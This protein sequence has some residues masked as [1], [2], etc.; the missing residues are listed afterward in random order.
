MNW[1]LPSYDKAIRI[2]ADFVLH[3]KGDTFG[4][5]KL[6]TNIARNT[7]KT[8]S[9]IKKE[10]KEVLQEGIDISLT[11]LKSLLANSTDKYNDLVLLEG[12][13]REVNQQLLQ[14]VITYENAQLEFNKIRKSLIDFI[15]T[16][17]ENHLKGKEAPD[18]KP[19]VYNGE[20]MYRIPKT[21]QIEK[22]VKC[23]VRVAFNRQVLM[24]GLDQEK[25][26]VLKDIRISDV[27]GVELL[28]PATTPAFSIRTFSEPVQFVE[29]D[30][31]TEWLFYVKPLCEGEHS[32]VLKISVIE[33]KE[34]I[35]RK[36][37]VVLE[38][39]VVIIAGPAPKPEEGEKFKPAGYALN[40]AAAAAA[41]SR[42]TTGGS[43]GHHRVMPFPIVPPSAPVVEVTQPQPSAPRP[44]TARRMR[45]LAVALPVLLIFVVASWALWSIF[46][47][48]L[49]NTTEGNRPSEIWN[50]VS[51]E[52][53]RKSLE[54]FIEKYPDTEEAAAARQKIDSLD[55]IFWES[56]LVSGDTAQIRQYLIEFPGGRHVTE[57][58]NRLNQRNAGG[59]PASA[60]EESERENPRAV[61]PEKETTRPATQPSGT[62]KPQRENRADVPVRSAARMPVY[63][64]CSN[65]NQKQEE[66]CTDQ[67]TGEFIS[68]RLEYPKVALR[69]RIEGTVK[70][71]F[72]VEK[73]GSI[74]D[75]QALNQL[76]GGC[77]EEA[78]RLVSMLPRFKPGL[79]I[80]GKPVRMQYFLPVKFRLN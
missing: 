19:D 5:P 3:R 30:L 13:Y 27:M 34:G 79:D 42:E 45:K 6:E 49:S 8:L 61:V 21:M 31:P 54:E 22:E 47:N 51:K 50:N 18:G 14:G 38:E 59:E 16:L 10:L 57:A 4:I 74:S 80:N 69:K 70:V 76:G 65:A 25:E 2:S 7:M 36:R 44:A 48:D 58:Q 37:N 15:E 11:T 62:T 12:R 24:E 46:G 32:L 17:E 52:N 64:N 9:D 20:V 41:V 66:E 53:D 43:K 56:A 29:K 1:C 26:D 67:K 72:V 71:S 35:E 73:D 55:A 75:V 63:P 78:V 77:E 40:F 60:P 68:K 23:I 28:D 39:T 33:I